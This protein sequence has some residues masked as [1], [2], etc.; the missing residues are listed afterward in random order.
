MYSGTPP[1][2]ISSAT[3][4][5]PTLTSTDDPIASWWIQRL[6]ESEANQNARRNCHLSNCDVARMAF[7]HPYRAQRLLVWRGEAE[8]KDVEYTKTT[9]REPIVYSYNEEIKH[10]STTGSQSTAFSFM[11]KLIL[12]TCLQPVALS[13][14]ASRPSQALSLALNLGKGINVIGGRPAWPSSPVT[15]YER[16]LRPA[17]HLGSRRS[18]ASLLPLLEALESLSFRP[19]NG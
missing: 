19:K 1:S 15:T 13:K 3:W 2:A 6:K 7:P 9:G 5:A 14:L 18:T 11:P 4:P 8:C 10:T 16:H 17:T 12:H